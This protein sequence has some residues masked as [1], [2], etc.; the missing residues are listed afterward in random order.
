MFL[1]ILFTIYNE[2]MKL[3]LNNSRNL[4]INFRVYPQKE[5]VTG[6]T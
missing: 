3:M 6:I 2:I 5:C 1:N 4:T